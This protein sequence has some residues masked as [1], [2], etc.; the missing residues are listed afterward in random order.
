L[1]NLIKIGNQEIAPKEFKGQRI[2]TFKDI[3]LVHE[4]P[5]GTA[6]RNFSENKKRFIEGQDYFEVTRSDVGTNFVETYGFGN[7]APKGT[8][9]T[10]QGYLMLVKSFNDDLAWKVQRD[11]VNTYFGVKTIKPLTTEQML[12]VQLNMI[13]DNTERIEKLEN[14]MVIDYGQQLVLKERVNAI[15]IHWLGGKESYAYK[16]IAKRVFSEC[17][18]DFQKYF[19]VNSRNNTPKL[20]FDDAVYYLA[21]W[22]PCMNTKLE[23]QG[24]NAQ[25]SLGA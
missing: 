20:K 13:D 11:L 12:R 22:E 10:E 25:M 18:K 7:T 9:I 24:C 16:D 19:N 23:I 21:H 1:N 2:V 4:R 8:L 5:D 6:G 15:V 14:N 3:D 17:N